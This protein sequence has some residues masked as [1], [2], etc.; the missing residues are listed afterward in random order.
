MNFG[1]D[2][3]EE[4]DDEYDNRFNFI[5][6]IT[7]KLSSTNIIIGIILV[8]IIIFLFYLFSPSTRY[9]RMERRM[10]KAAQK[11]VSDNFIDVN[12]EVYLDANTINFDLDGKCGKASGVFF[13]GNDYK[14]YLY[15][16]GYESRVVNNN[17]K[18]IKINGSSVILLVKGV[19]FNDPGYVSQGVVNIIGEVGNEEGVYTL[20]YYDIE[21]NG[22]ATRKVVILDNKELFDNIPS[23][24]LNGNDVVHV[25][26]GEEYRDEGAIATD[27]E[28]N[29]ITDNIKVHGNVNNNEYG[30]YLLVYSITNND[31]ITNSV[32]RM[33]NV[34]DKN[35]TLN[36]D[37]LVNPLTVVNTSVNISLKITGND[38]DYVLLPDNTKSS[39]SYINYKV[40][41]N[42]T[43]VFLIYDKAGREI[44]KEIKISNIDKDLPLATCDAVI[45]SNYANIV[46]NSLSARNISSYEYNVN[47]TKQKS[48]SSTFH[49]DSANI[50]DASVTLNNTSGNK[51]VI[52]CEIATYNNW[53]TDYS[54]SIV[55]IKS[56]TSNDILKKYTLADYLMGV[57]YKELLDIDFASFTND[58]LKNLFKTL[59][60]IK[61]A[62][63]LKNGGYNINLKQL[64]FTVDNGDYCDVY[65]GCKLVNKNNKNFYLANDIEYNVGSILSSKN[66]LNDEI[67]KIMKEAY[68][69]TR[70]EVIT[71][72]NFKQVLTKYTDGFVFNESIKDSIINEVKSGNLYQNI[73][74][75]LYNNYQIYNIEN[76]SSKYVES[77]IQYFWPTGSIDSPDSLSI[78]HNYGA[79]ITDN[80]IYDYLA[81]KGECNSTNV[82]AAWNGIVTQTGYSSETGNFVIIDHGDG[83]KITYGSLSKNSINVTVGTNV[84]RGDTIGRVDQLNNSCML[85]IK[86][87]YNDIVTN[88]LD[89]ISNINPRP[90]NGES[91]IYVPGNSV[92]ESVCLSLVASGISK[93]AVA[94]VM[95]NMYY[96]SKFNLQTL[97]DGGTSYGLC[98]WHSSR[99]SQ[100]KSYCGS[101]L[102]TVDCQ[103]E[104]L[105]YELNRG[106]GGTT[107]NYVFGNY[108]AYDVGYKFCYSYEQ[109]TSASSG[110]CERRGN[111]AQNEY[112]PYVLNGCQ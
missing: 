37:Y 5:R 55:F 112:L 51:N 93:E 44:K 111:T 50:N 27:K 69:E 28:S 4:E 43:Y 49:Y 2:D 6:V 12:H 96:E 108:S 61:K 95:A 16:N 11:Y 104:Y 94:G 54:K 110:G 18:N 46:V 71:S 38:F 9:G 81:I 87:T 78:I 29:V 26:K 30:Q 1:Y 3:Y 20:H 92:K 59:F 98:Q 70:K 57:V 65:A 89:Y 8:L 7:D 53:K 105:F 103:L 76:Y 10:V 25:F 64:I 24:Y 77:K 90:A 17:D 52:N 56:D 72:I 32:S 88:P 97:G 47:G 42:G 107:K 63:V 41:K 82:I 60:V 83:V 22:V 74:K 109:P 33:V 21:N 106:Y 45:Y 102:D 99:M 67:I 35:M 23:I 39:N 19:Y 14:P 79:S 58:Q 34:V 15:C 31:G 68:D 75:K 84:K 100:L 101:R 36:A 73:I 66:K 40:E 91:I 62:E 48:I 86:A 80:K 13:D 85:Y